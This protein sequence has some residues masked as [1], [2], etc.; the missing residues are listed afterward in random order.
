MV[1][2]MLVGTKLYQVT[3]KIAQATI[4]LAKKKY[5]ESGQHT[6]VGVQKAD[7]LALQKD[8]FPTVEE[9]MEAVAGWEKSGYT[10]YHTNEKQK[11]DEQV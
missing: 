8:I 6:I 11:E 5:G 4:D 1:I 2:K 10:C 3:E 7:L 9:L